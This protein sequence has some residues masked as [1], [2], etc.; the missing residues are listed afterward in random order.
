MF[1]IISFFHSPRFT[2]L[3]P[4]PPTPPLESLYAEVWDDT[5]LTIVS[6]ALMGNTRKLHGI[7][8]LLRRQIGLYKTYQQWLLAHNQLLVYMV[9]AYILTEHCN[10]IILILQSYRRKHSSELYYNNII[11]AQQSNLRKHSSE[12]SYDWLEHILRL[13]IICV[14]YMDWLAWNF[15]IS[16]SMC[17]QTG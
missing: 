11:L 14:Q 6:G 10:S 7:R 9:S 1:L 12:L 5:F 15:P 3:Q 17:S 13:Q 16:T 4:T 2:A 8:D